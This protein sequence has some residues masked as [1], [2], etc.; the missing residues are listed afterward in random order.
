M[1]FVFG[2]NIR[3]TVL[4]PGLQEIARTQVSTHF[5]NK[6]SFFQVIFY[7]ARINARVYY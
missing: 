6:A 7:D 4:K 3:F 1:R 5:Y 2:A